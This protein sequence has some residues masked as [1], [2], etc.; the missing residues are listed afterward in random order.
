MTAVLVMG[1]V[2]GGGIWWWLQDAANVPFQTPSQETVNARAASIAVLPFDNLSA[3]EEQVYFADGMTEDIITALS[4]VQGLY[5]TSR[6]AT[7]RYRK[8]RAD[9]RAIGDALGVRNILG[10]VRR[11]EA[12]VR[13]TATLI[14]AGTGAQ[15]WAERYDREARDLFAIQDEIAEHVVSRLSEELGGETLTRATRTYASNLDAYDLYIQ[16][17]A[18]RIPPTPGNLEAAHALFKEA[19]ELDPKFAGGYAGAAYVLVLRYSNKPPHVASVDEDLES[20]LQM[21]ERA[22][23]LDP[24]FGPGWGSLTE[25]YLRKGQFDEALLAAR[26]AMEEAPSDS[27][28]R[29]TYGRLLGHIGRPGEGIK[30]VRAAMRMSPDSLPLLYFLGANYRAAGEFDKAIEALKE[31]R[32]RLGGRVLPMPTSQLIAAYAQAG[33]LD[34]ARAGANGLLEKYPGFTAGTAAKTH[35]YKDP[36]EKAA[37]VDSLRSAGLPD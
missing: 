37:F 1:A 22:T 23:E 19:I 14:D 6:S 26:R 30:E 7:M 25:A 36:A 17:R 33:R 31:H 5:V 34:D 15:L 10:S 3:D 20:A 4:K 13:I 29:A 32:L 11:D 9:P 8:D 16:G 2:V 21:A 12:K 18:K 24:S 27:L 35:V 28:M